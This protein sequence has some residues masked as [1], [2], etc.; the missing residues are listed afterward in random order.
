MGFLFFNEQRTPY[1]E[2]IFCTFVGG[3]Q[4]PQNSNDPFSVLIGKLLFSL[5]FNNDSY[6]LI[7]IPS[8]LALNRFENISCT[9]P[10]VLFSNDRINISS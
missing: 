10:P 9:A 2:L 5:L 6:L 1:C 3:L 7:C 8:L 4:L